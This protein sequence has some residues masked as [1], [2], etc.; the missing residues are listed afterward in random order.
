MRTTLDIDDALL[1][2]ART[3][4]RERGTSLGTAV[5]ELI[6]RGL[7]TPAA[8]SCSGFPIFPAPPGAPVVTNEVVN[9][10]RDDDTD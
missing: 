9:R 7:A 2:V 3:R 5:S 6:R 8:E 1:A 4:A 10:H